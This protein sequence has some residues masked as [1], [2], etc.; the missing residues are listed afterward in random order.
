[1]T[2]L[3]PLPYANSDL[4]S[5]RGRRH[6]QP[7]S[8]PTHLCVSSCEMMTAK[9]AVSIGLSTH[10][11]PIH[12]WWTTR[13][14]QS[15]KIHRPLPLEMRTRGLWCGWAAGRLT[16]G[17][18]RKLI[19]ADVLWDS[20]REQVNRRWVNLQQPPSACQTPLCNTARRWHFHI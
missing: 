20:C 1:M 10:F 13:Q 8:Q 6:H 5:V 9:Y 15:V 17:V 2:I 14:L 11:A 19:W 12:F 3:S 4:L 7:G 18:R 16:P